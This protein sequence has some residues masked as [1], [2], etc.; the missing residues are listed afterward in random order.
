MTY[1]IY[2]CD[3]CQEVCPWNGKPAPQGKPDFQ[4]REDLVAPPLETLLFF[5]DDAFRERFRK[6]PIKRAKREGF[7]RNVSIALG[8]WGT[9]DAALLLQEIKQQDPSPLVQEHVEWALKQCT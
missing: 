1:R 3:I 8:N 7:M 5:D 9:R 2:G 4:V 6:S